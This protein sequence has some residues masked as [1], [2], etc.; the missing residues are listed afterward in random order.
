MMKKH[1]K[2]TLALLLALAMLFS[3]AACAKQ[4]PAPSA[5]PSAEPSPTPEAA[6]AEP[7][8]EPDTPAGRAAARGLPEPPDID[9]A[10]REY[11]VNNSYN[12]ITEYDLSIENRY[13]GVGGQGRSEEHTSE[14]QSPR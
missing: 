8:P 4:A 6:P 12:S 5:E 9:I 13:S 10:D 2:T 1:L 14:L 3:L 7:T 11:I